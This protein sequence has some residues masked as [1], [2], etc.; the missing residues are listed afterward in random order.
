[1]LFFLLS[2]SGLPPDIARVTGALGLLD[3][4]TICREALDAGQPLAP[5]LAQLHSVPRGAQAVLAALAAAGSGA[6]GG[7]GGPPLPPPPPA[8]PPLDP[9]AARFGAERLRGWAPHLAV[10]ALEG[11]YWEALAGAVGVG[12]LQ[13]ARPAQL[14]LQRAEQAEQAQAHAGVKRE[15]GGEGAP[16]AAAAPGGD[17]K[18]SRRAE[19]AAAARERPGGEAGRAAAARAA[20]IEMALASQSGDEGE[21][22]SA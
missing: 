20:V 12:A 2:H 6:G 8:A 22:L 18:R 3:V 10:D 1:V 9:E 21:Y 19:A 7:S 13:G 11:A 5:V 14:H 4:F 15:P 17:R 16:A